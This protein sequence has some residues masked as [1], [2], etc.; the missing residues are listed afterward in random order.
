M[1][2]N[3]AFDPNLRACNRRQ[4]LPQ[5]ATNENLISETL[6][7]TAALDT[8]MPL[9]GTIVDGMEQLVT[10]AVTNLMTY[11]SEYHFIACL[12]TT[13]IGNITY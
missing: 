1:L 11:T 10:S 2:Q 6:A 4:L 13:L 7:F 3:G 9:R 8:N 12:D 5:F